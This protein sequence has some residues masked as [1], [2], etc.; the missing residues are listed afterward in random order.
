MAEVQRF[1]ERRHAGG[2]FRIFDLRGEAGVA[3]DADKF[4]GPAHVARYPFFDHNPA[5]L[6]T[7]RDCV[8]D[9][10][11]FLAAHADNVVAFHCKVRSAARSHTHAE[12]A[13]HASAVRACERG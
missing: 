11:R 12:R 5:P 2:R 9:A 10:H 4:G 1:F 7:I 8:V 3:Y 13:V 6:A